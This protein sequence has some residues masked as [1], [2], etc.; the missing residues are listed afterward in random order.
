[1]FGNTNSINSQ[2]VATI[3][4]ESYSTVSSLH[5]VDVMTSFDKVILDNN[6]FDSYIGALTESLDMK[7]KDF[8]V[9]SSKKYKRAN[10]T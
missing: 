5:E 3:L 1:M 9:K 4:T 2:A 6:V 7:T 8:M 10:I